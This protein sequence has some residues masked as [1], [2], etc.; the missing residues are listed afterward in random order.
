[1]PIDQYGNHR[2]LSKALRGV[3]LRFSVFFGF[4]MLCLVSLTGYMVSRAVMGLAQNSWITDL[5][6]RLAVSEERLVAFKD[7]ALIFAANSYVT[8]GIID[9]AGRSS[10][11]P[12]ELES[13]KN[14]RGI[15][16]AGVMDYSGKAIDLSSGFPTEQIDRALLRY[17]VE[18]GRYRMWCDGS[19]RRVF[20]AAPINY[21]NTPQ[22]A[23][24]LVTDFP[25]IAKGGDMI[26]S[27]SSVGMIQVFCR[28]HVIFSDGDKPSKYSYSFDLSADQNLHSLGS[29]IGLRMSATVSYLQVYKPAIEISLRL[30][31]LGVIFVIGGGFI[32]RRIEKA[33]TDARDLALRASNA[34]SQFLANMSHEIRTPLNGVMGNLNLLLE[35][36]LTGEQ[37]QIASDARISSQS[38]LALLNDI[39]DFS[40]IDA[41]QVVM[42]SSAVNVREVC[43]AVERTFH[44]IMEEKRL[45]CSVSIS[46]GV[47]QFIFED[48]LRLRQ[49]LNNLFSN[50][51]KFTAEG[52]IKLDVWHEGGVLLFAVIDSGIGISADRI[53]LL[54]SPFIQ[55]EAST[56]R[57]FG[58]TGLGLSICRELARMMG[59]DV[60][61]KSQAG[62]GST[63]T[64]RIPF[65]EVVAPEEPI[66]VVNE[67]SVVTNV[68]ALRV[69]VVE[70]N[71]VNKALMNKMLM[72]YGSDVQFATNGAEAVDLAQQHEFDLIFMDCQMP[73]MDGFEATRQIIKML[74]DARPMVVALT[75]NAFKEDQER[76][77]QAGMDNYLSKPV[78]RESLE[79]IMR[80]VQRRTA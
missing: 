74:G 45:Q 33:L 66:K 43:A 39:L 57:R 58:G 4:A 48:G 55:A 40:K 70:D 1:M 21:Y 26:P 67:P 77:F 30:A 15:A 37:H 47:P 18:T 3:T 79:K 80:S 16:F 63:F 11:L 27:Q 32:A 25:T 64:L 23:L 17:A 78:S 6:R 50:A 73:V 53:K 22:G 13:M 12:R 5:E 14:A 41:G 2:L 28:D 60:T 72:K 71:P 61:V 59:G 9:V 46:E 24:I 10:Y 69:L 31:A 19:S 34:R 52:T 51:I 36:T 76:C 7:A 35:Q 49:I 65:T 8:N 56:T 75:A 44:G 62:V 42:E 20:I 38:L 68:V 29:M 54:F